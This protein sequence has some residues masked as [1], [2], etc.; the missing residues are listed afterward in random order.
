MH[1]YYIMVN[2]AFPKEGVVNTNKGRVLV[3]TAFPNKGGVLVNTK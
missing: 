2:T 1:A 3:N